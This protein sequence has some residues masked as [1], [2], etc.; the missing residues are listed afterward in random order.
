VGAQLSFVRGAATV[1]LFLGNKHD[2]LP[3]QRLSAAVAPSATTAASVGPLPAEVG[4][5]QQVQVVLQ[6]QVLQ[7]IAEPP[8]LQVGAGVRE[9]WGAGWAGMGRGWGLALAAGWLICQREALLMAAAL[10]LQAAPC[11]AATGLVQPA[12]FALPSPPSH[13]HHRTQSA[14]PSPAHGTPAPGPPPTAPPPAPA[15]PT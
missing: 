6:L 13:L 12:S 8:V 2:S 5:K 3:I 14:Q 15:P 1:T 9:C 11:S 4:P 7:P 10:Q